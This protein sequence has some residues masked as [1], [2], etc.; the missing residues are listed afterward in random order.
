[1]SVGSR[2]KDTARVSL[3]GWVL[4]GGGREHTDPSGLCIMSQKVTLC[5]DSSQMGPSP[6]QDRGSQHGSH[7][8]SGPEWSPGLSRAPQSHIRKVLHGYQTIS[9]EEGAKV[10]MPCP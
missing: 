3:T 2:L 10:F 7:S 6:P 8:I 5:I 9:M 4:P 1:M